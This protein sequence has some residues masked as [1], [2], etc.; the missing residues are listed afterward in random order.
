MKKLGER[1][2]NG[3]SHFYLMHLS[4]EGEERERLWSYA[5]TPS[6]EMIGLDLPNEVIMDWE[7]IPIIDKQRFHKRRPVWY[8]QFETFC[9]LMNDG[10]IVV[11]MSGWN[12]ILGIGRI[13]VENQTRP[14]DYRKELIGIFFDHVRKVK[15]EYKGNPIFLK[16]SLTGFN[17]TLLDIK[18]SSSLW[19]KISNAD[20]AS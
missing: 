13:I 3:Q 8:N 5:I 2:L 16:T 4:Y 19:E 10:D 1:Y 7:D 20:L 6:N 11:I 18:P 9:K 17:N 12:P 15:W 14:Y